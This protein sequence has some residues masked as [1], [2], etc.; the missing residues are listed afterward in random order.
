ME[1]FRE[2]RSIFPFLVNTHYRSAWNPEVSILPIAA[3][4]C[5]RFSEESVRMEITTL[6]CQG[7]SNPKLSH[8]P[9]QLWTPL[10][11]LF[12]TVEPGL[13]K[14]PQ[15]T[16]RLALEPIPWLLPVNLRLE[17]VPNAEQFS[18]L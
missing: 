14:S 3:E 10:L 18:G 12:V 7:P 4:I 16:S 11:S 5:L 2:K 9:S 6:P 13:H 1:G 17:P 8:C 15:R